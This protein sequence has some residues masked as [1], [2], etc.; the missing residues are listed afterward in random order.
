MEKFETTDYVA[1]HRSLGKLAKFL[2]EESVLEGTA[3]VS[4]DEVDG[5]A[6][7]ITL[8]IIDKGE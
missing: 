3:T 1:L 4:S 7:E 5:I 6:V 2:V 8:S